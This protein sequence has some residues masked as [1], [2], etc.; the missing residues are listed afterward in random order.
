MQAISMCA[1]NENMAKRERTILFLKEK[2]ELIK[3]QMSAGRSQR[4]LAEPFWS[5]E[6]L[7]Y[8]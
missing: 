8:K 2:V 6:K 1:Y 3:L 4:D 5:L 7:K